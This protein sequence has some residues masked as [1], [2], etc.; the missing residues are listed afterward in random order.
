MGTANREAVE[1]EVPA[2]EHADNTVEDTGLVLHQHGHH[3]L[4]W[5]LIIGVITVHVIE[6]VT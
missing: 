6:R 1:V 3:M 4:A 5:L 2:A